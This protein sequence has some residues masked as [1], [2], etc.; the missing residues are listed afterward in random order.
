MKESACG[1]GVAACQC[2]DPVRLA[3]RRNR[4]SPAAESADRPPAH[5]T[6]ATRRQLSRGLQAIGNDPCLGVTDRVKPS[7]RGS[8]QNQPV[9]LSQFVPV[10]PSPRKGICDSPIPRLGMDVGP[11][12]TTRRLLDHIG[13]LHSTKDSDS[14]RL[15]SRVFQRIIRWRIHVGYWH[16]WRRLSL[17]PREPG[18]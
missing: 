16:N 13:S 15:A 11:A 3:L 9:F 5:H 8:G 2:F 14:P 7:H 12:R 1:T 18:A 4:C 6:Q 10:L 17:G